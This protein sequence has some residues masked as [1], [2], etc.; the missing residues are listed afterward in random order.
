MGGG[1]SPRRMYCIDD[2]WDWT[3]VEEGGLEG[4]SLDL[5]SI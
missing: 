5:G 3:A 2:T 4:R 1:E